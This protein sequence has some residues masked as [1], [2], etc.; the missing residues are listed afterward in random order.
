MK[1]WIMTIF[2][3]ANKL[4][5]LADEIAS[6]IDS[7]A[8]CLTMDTLKVFS[9]VM[10]L[11]D[12]KRRLCNFKVLADFFKSKLDKEQ[13]EIVKKYLIKG[14]SFEQIAYGTGLSRSTT[15]RR[16]NSAINKSIA[17]CLSLTYDEDRLMEEYKDFPVIIKTLGKFKT[18]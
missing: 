4:A 8:V 13:L 15:I 5:K 2:F 6:E 12:K 3:L 10:N 16:Y 9:T 11:E 18:S 14:D 7:Y 1:Y 17:A